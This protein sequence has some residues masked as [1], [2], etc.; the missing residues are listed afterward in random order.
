[1]TKS[2][3]ANLLQFATGASKVPP[4]GFEHLEGLSGKLRFNIVR[5]DGSVDLLP[6]AHTCFTPQLIYRSTQ[7]RRF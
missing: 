7:R 5:A 4:G 6:V 3:K 1:M 2:D